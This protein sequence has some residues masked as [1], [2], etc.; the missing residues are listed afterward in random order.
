MRTTAR[1]PWSSATNQLFQTGERLAKAIEGVTD[2]RLHET[3]PERKYSFYYLFHS[4]VQ[5]SLYHAGQIALPKKSGNG[6]VKMC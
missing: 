5:H 1:L 6:S 2:E 4:I 3:T